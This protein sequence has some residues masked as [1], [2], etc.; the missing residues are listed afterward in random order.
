MFLLTDFGFGKISLLV[1]HAL[2]LTN[3]LHESPAGGPDAA[4]KGLHAELGVISDAFW[5]RL[6]TM[7]ALGFA[8]A[9]ILHIWGRFLRRSHIRLPVSTVDS[10][11]CLSIPEY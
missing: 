7:V 3:A 5:V 6:S 11:S 8:E 4:E 10:T 2:S 9:N 1:V